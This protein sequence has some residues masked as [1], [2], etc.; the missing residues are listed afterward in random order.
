M[1]A[2]SF[3]NKNNEARSHVVPRFSTDSQMSLTEQFASRVWHSMASDV[4]IS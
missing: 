1:T 2:S 4:Y 3:M